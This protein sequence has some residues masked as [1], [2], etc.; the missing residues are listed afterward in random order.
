MG[1]NNVHRHLGYNES[2]GCAV[3]GGIRGKGNCVTISNSGKHRKKAGKLR[4]A[5]RNRTVASLKKTGKIFF[6]R[7]AEISGVNPP[8]KKDRTRV[9]YTG[10]CGNGT[11]EGTSCRRPFKDK[12][13]LFEANRETSEENKGFR[14]LEGTEASQRFSNEAVLLNYTT[15]K[16]VELLAGM[17]A[18]GYVRRK[19]LGN[20]GKNKPD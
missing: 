18:E 10:G 19:S 20:T 7:P 13:S 4:G 8:R 3:P 12:T 5:T 11:T 6:A 9:R 15:A 14:F 1:S 2:S 16:R 17:I